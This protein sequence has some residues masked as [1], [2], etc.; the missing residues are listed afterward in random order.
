[1]ILLVGSKVKF[2]SEN[3]ARVLIRGAISEM[4]KFT[5]K[6]KLSMRKKEKRNLHRV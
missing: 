5:F 3:I 1:M 6:N 2:A 4:K